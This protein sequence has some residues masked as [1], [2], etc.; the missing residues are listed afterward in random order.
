[1]RIDTLLIWIT[2]G[3]NLGCWLYAQLI[4]PFSAGFYLLSAIVLAVALFFSL[5]SRQ[6][7]KSRQIARMS[8]LESVMI[9]Y[10]LLSQ[11]AMNYAENQFSVLEKDMLL[12][13]QTIQ[14]SVKTLST[15]LTGLEKQS[16]EQRLVLKTLIEEMLLMTGANTANDPNRAD[17]QKFFDETHLLINEFVDKMEELSLSSN[18]IAVSFDQMQSKFMRI[19][20]SL[21][22]VTKLTRQTDTLA[23]NA[24]I[25]AARAG[26]A[27]RGFGVVSD[28]VRKLA[29]QTRQFSEEIRFTLDDIMQSLKEVGMHVTQATK[30]DLSLAEHS[31][32]NLAN[33]GQELLNMTSTAK[34]HS[35]HITEVTDQIQQLA[36]EGVIAMQFEDI[37]TQMMNRIAQD[38]QQVGQYLH[39]FLQL[40][41]D[42]DQQDGLTRFK[43]RV[44][45]LKTLLSSTSN[46]NHFHGS[47]DSD[48][49]LF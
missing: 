3:L 34:N 47:R 13:R 8:E 44:T 24:A 32:E 49:E 19:E 11:Q 43:N 27:G 42:S 21:D 28:E 7:W 20:E 33:L 9:E 4:G 31:R 46:V 14:E 22:G 6:Q 37:V 48:I 29:S 1:M 5:Q 26:P 23:L 30:T 17:L 39:K 41:Q 40:H 12:A 25:E 18:S 35:Q 10:Q 16:T 36:Q 45:L 15:S 38:T 2:L